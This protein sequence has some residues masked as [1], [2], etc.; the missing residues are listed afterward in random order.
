MDYLA[1]AKRLVPA[2]CCQLLTLTGCGVASS[3]DFLLPRG[4]MVGAT[5][6]S[7]GDGLCDRTEDF[8]GTVS[9]EPDTD[10][11]GLPDGSEAIAGAD[12][13][14][15][16][17]PATDHVLYL[18]PSAGE[19]T[20]DILV[21]IDGRGGPANGSIVSRS[22]LDPESR[23]A[24]DFFTG[25]SAADAQPPDNARNIQMADA[26]FGS[27]IGHAR[28][29]FLASFMADDPAEPRAAGCA[30]SL[31]FDF[32]VSDDDGAPLSRETYLLVV[33]ASEQTKPV[34]FCRPTACL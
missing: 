12:P 3:R 20:Y 7:D 19:V 26:R 30:S 10:S 23:H 18:P 24:G 28:L 13:L 11:D 4:A 29:H 15:N 14:S 21:T 8:L 16:A 2:A 31:P 22:S 25:C 27:V 5:F 34:S 9:H 33:D 6:D 17:D 1:I 32:V